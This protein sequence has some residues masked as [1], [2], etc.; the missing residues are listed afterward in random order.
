MTG[1]IY[2]T[3]SCKD[4]LWLLLRHPEAQYLRNMCEALVLLASTKPAPTPA[5]GADSLSIESLLM[6]PGI[7]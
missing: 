7:Y 6:G 5:L 2:N 4:S 3:S 1:P